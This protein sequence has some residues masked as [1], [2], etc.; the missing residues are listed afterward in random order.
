MNVLKNLL[1]DPYNIDFRFIL[2]NMKN[3]LNDTQIMMLVSDTYFY[4]FGSP[5]LLVNNEKYGGNKGSLRYKNVN[6]ST[7]FRTLVQQIVEL[8]ENDVLVGYNSGDYHSGVLAWDSLIIKKF[9]DRFSSNQYSLNYVEL[10]KKLSAKERAQLQEHIQNIKRKDKYIMVKYFK[11][12]LDFSPHFLSPREEINGIKK[13]APTPNVM[14]YG[15]ALIISKTSR[16]FKDWDRLSSVQKAVQ[17]IDILINPSF[18]RF[19]KEEVDNKCLL[20][21]R[22]SYD[23]RSIIEFYPK[24]FDQYLTRESEGHFCTSLMLD[25]PEQYRKYISYKIYQTILFYT[26]IRLNTFDAEFVQDSFGNVY[27]RNVIIIDMSLGDGDCSPYMAY[28]RQKGIFLKQCS[29]GMIGFHHFDRFSKEQSEVREITQ[30]VMKKGFFNS[31]DNPKSIQ[32]AL[33]ADM[34]QVLHNGF[35][36][37]LQLQ[38]EFLRPELHDV[39]RVYGLLRPDNVMLRPNLTSNIYGRRGDKYSPDKSHPFRGT[40]RREITNGFSLRPPTVGYSSRTQVRP[41]S[42]IRVNYRPVSTPARNVFSL[43]RRSEISSDNSYEPDQKNTLRA[44]SKFMGGIQKK[45]KL[46]DNLMRYFKRETRKK[47]SLIRNR[48]I[49]SRKLDASIH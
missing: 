43:S 29:E 46:E 42:S 20:F 10:I 24:S 6:S 2:Q 37:E 47:A 14:D 17:S 18:F 9:K 36:E 11:I 34:K 25:D 4:E 40:P 5:K 16:A 23:C 26:N 33:N 28:Q 27:L 39:N 15:N 22:A 7:Q 12:I 1:T 49:A 38:G 3:P 41:T 21:L 13:L 32:E 35:K 31:F 19:K 48:S 30:N 44:I 45:K 8:N